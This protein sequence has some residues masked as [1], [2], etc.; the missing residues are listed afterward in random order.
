MEIEGLHLKKG[1]K[2][3]EIAFSKEILFSIENYIYFAALT[4]KKL[5]LKSLECKRGGRYYDLIYYKG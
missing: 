4:E 5:V 1:T 3:N 2:T